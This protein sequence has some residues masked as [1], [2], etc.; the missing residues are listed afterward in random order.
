MEVNQSLGLR[1]YRHARP[2]LLFWRENRN[3]TTFHFLFCT[4][5]HC[6]YPVPKILKSRIQS[7]SPDNLSRFMAAAPSQSGKT[8]TAT[9]PIIIVILVVAAA[10]LGY[11]QIAYYPSGHVS[12]ST[13]SQVIATTPYNVTVTIP[14]GAP[15]LPTPQTFSPDHIVVV[16]GYNST[17]FWKNADP[18]AHTITSPGGSPDTRFDTFGPNN[19]QDYNIIQPAGTPGDIL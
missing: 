15:S 11:Y 1:D 6:P 8:L 7:A 19:P 13:T 4:T 10:L 16:L 9:G 12:T 17:V 3:V 5:S 18:V 2:F 14:V